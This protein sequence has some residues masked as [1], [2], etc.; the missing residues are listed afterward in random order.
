MQDRRWIIGLVVIAII[1]VLSI[2][3]LNWDKKEESL[4]D[5]SYNKKFHLEYPQYTRPE[6]FEKHR[7]PKV[8][9]SGNHQ[10]IEEWRQKKSK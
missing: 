3:G 7:V 6:V 2:W 1:I 5:E 10:K 4:T 9:L 8:L